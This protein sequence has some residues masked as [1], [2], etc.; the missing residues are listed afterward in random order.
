MEFLTV[1][2]VQEL[3]SLLVKRRLS[4]SNARTISLLSVCLTKDPKSI[5][6]RWTR[7]FKNTAHC[8]NKSEKSVTCLSMDKKRG[9]KRTLEH[10]FHNLMN[11]CLFARLIH[12]KNLLR[13]MKSLK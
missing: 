6:K 3:I 7:A 8:C 9:A 2:Q 11:K 4:A 1:T 5:K 12:V 10:V 13:K